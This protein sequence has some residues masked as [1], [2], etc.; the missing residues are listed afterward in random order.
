MWLVD[1]EIDG[2]AER[3]AYLL[4][5]AHEQRRNL[6]EEDLAFALRLSPRTIRDWLRGHMSERKLVS[7]HGYGYWAPTSRLATSWRAVGRPPQRRR[8]VYGLWPPRDKGYC[9]ACGVER[10]ERA[11]F[12]GGCSLR[13]HEE[14]VAF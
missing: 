5:R 11:R 4:C 12:C 3:L 10:I 6:S 1:E 13:V 8:R 9:P 14:D 2:T 7:Q